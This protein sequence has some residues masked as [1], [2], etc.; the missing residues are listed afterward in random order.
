[1]QIHVCYSVRGTVAI[2]GGR[3]IES[4]RLGEETI[5]NTTYTFTTAIAETNSLA[6]D[7]AVIN[8]SYFKIILIA[9]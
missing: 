7:V 8:Y 3:K 2:Q 4:E 6:T 1:M 9:T 5:N